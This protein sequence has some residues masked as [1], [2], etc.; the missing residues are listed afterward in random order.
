MIRLLEDNTVICSDGANVNS[1]HPE[2]TTCK[3]GPKLTKVFG[4]QPAFI[5]ERETDDQHIKEI[6]FDG[7]LIRYTV[8]DCVVS[9]YPE[10]PSAKS[11][12]GNPKLVEESNQ[13]TFSYDP[14]KN[15]IEFL[16]VF[17][18]SGTLPPRVQLFLDTVITKED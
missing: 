3:L 16:N 10:P 12:H 18:P 14:V 9:D 2:K 13:E 7:K 6:A 15:I 8:V 17:A 1:N 11:L 5:Y 4:Y